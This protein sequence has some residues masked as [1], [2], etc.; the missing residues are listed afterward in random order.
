MTSPITLVLLPAGGTEAAAPPSAVEDPAL[1][2]AALLAALQSA[3]ITGSVIAVP[4]NPSP[5]AQQAEVQDER[6]GDAQDSRG[7]EAVPEGRIVAVGEGGC[8][9]VADLMIPTATRSPN[10]LSSAREEPLPV[11]IEGGEMAAPKSAAPAEGGV[12]TPSGPSVAGTETRIV[13]G[14]GEA[15]P[16]MRTIASDRG[17]FRRGLQPEKRKESESNSAATEESAAALSGKPKDL[18]KEPRTVAR[19]PGV[20]PARV[21]PTPHVTAVEAERSVVSD[22]AEMSASAPQ[23]EAKAAPQSGGERQQATGDPQAV[24]AEVVFRQAVTVEQS[25]PRRDEPRPAAVPPDGVA[26]DP[27]NE[28]T[29]AVRPRA[30]SPEPAATRMSSPRDAQTLARFPAA[31]ENDPQP[32]TA[33]A[34][35]SRRQLEPLGSESRSTP[36]EEPGSSAPA[37]PMIAAMIMSAPRATLFNPPEPHDTR[38][39]SAEPT[40]APDAGEAAATGNAQWAAQPAREDLLEA[41][42]E[43]SRGLAFAQEL[44]A[45]LGDAEFADIKL[46][47]DQGQAAGGRRALVSA[48]PAKAPVT[49]DPGSPAPAQFAASGEP[50]PPTAAVTGDARVGMQP[51]SAVSRPAT[52]HESSARRPDDDLVTAA[53]SASA[54]SIGD[55]VAAPK[56]GAIAPQAPPVQRERS[57]RDPVPPR[58]PIVPAIRQELPLPAPRRDDGISSPRASEQSDAREPSD[59]QRGGSGPATM[60]SEAAGRVA[61]Q[62]REA[63]SGEARN[64]PDGTET[65]QRPAV[66]AERVTLQVADADGRQT[67]IRVSVQGDQVRAVIVPA[68]QEA[69]QHLERRMDDLQEALVKQGFPAPKV[70]VQSPA[71]ASGG[72]SWGAPPSGTSN[73]NASGRGMDQPSEER[74]QGSGRQEQNRHG[75]GQRHPQQRF[76]QGDRDDRQNQDAG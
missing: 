20:R 6:Q 67:R 3:M 50:L 54:P 22:A 23:P 16:A 17:E 24:R 42:A 7:P 64:L 19:A 71:S 76:R 14:T 73:E 39:P 56:A 5:P 21:A 58:A 69:A 33:E 18:S 29:A 26:D 57:S 52:V 30:V 27:T 53:T 65:K 49:A 9:A 4:V 55:V 47:V 62:S 15:I 37:P 72:L 51:A 35:L 75:G 44:A 25:A 66:L 8:A 13:H 34:R 70:T 45:L 10:P 38:V 74:G 46:R 61:A 11:A 28:H 32:S 41:P 43:A 1:F 48:P 68:D 40:V 60:P 12:A 63:P 2:T 31:P 59:S 36:I